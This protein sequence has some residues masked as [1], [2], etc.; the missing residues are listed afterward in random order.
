MSSTYSRFPAR[1]RGRGGARATVGDPTPNPRELTRGLATSPIQTLDKPRIVTEEEI[2]VDEVAY[3]GSYN[4]IEAEKPT[5]LVP[6]MSE[7][8]RMS[9]ALLRDLVLLPCRLTEYLD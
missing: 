1:G 7:P 9:S 4:W 3:L 2:K 5:I 8:I 6:G